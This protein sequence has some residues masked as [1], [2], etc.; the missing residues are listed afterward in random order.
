VVKDEQGVQSISEW[1][2]VSHFGRM[3]ESRQYPPDAYQEQSALQVLQSSGEQIALR[4]M[5]RRSD[6]ALL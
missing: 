2:A 1:H 5:S 4:Q 3:K 6:E